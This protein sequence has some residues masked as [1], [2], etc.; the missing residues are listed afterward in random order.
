MNVYNG[1][2][3]FFNKSPFEIHVTIAFEAQLLECT[4]M[5]RFL[6]GIYLFG[7]VKKNKKPLFFF[8]NL[9]SHFLSKFL[10]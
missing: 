7:K 2:F 10:I 8:F 4:W 5:H 9:P 6:R 1:E 3:L